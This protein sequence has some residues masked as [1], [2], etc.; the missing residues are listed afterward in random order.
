MPLLYE[1]PSERLAVELGDVKISASE[2]IDHIKTA[3]VPLPSEFPEKLLLEI[4]GSLIEL[5]D[6]T[7]RGCREPLLFAQEKLA[8]IRGEYIGREDADSSYSEDT[9]PRPLRREP[10]D[11]KL[12]ALMSSVSTA[13]Q[14]ANREMAVL[15]EYEELFDRPVEPPRDGSVSRLGRM[16]RRGEKSLATDRQELDEIRDPDS[17]NADRLRRRL[18]DALSL[19]RLAR[20]ELGMRRIVPSWLLRISSTLREYP[21]LIV[22][23]SSV[24]RASA[25]IADWAHDKWSKYNDKL[26]RVGTELVRE[27]SSDL[28]RYGSDLEEYRKN[29]TDGLPA[30]TFSHRAARDLILN[31]K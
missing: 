20:T 19:N 25:D 10:L 1:K 13:L 3:N 12:V 14:A 28:A 21:K 30:S 2:L 27:I 24:M 17:I 23:A 9:A 16:V 5:P 8:A 22:A 4:A 31:G 11:Q 15:P 7:A 18:T 29:Q 6:G 26:F